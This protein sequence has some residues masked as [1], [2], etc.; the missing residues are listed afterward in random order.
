M[1]AQITQLVIE[2]LKESENSPSLSNAE[3]RRW[4]EI[5]A[6]IQRTSGHSENTTND[7]LQ[8]L[9]RE[10]IKNWNEITDHM[11]KWNHPTVENATQVKLYTNR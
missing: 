6:S 5:S 7:P 2:K 1:I 4:N 3:I 8:A 10:E 9:S 11:N